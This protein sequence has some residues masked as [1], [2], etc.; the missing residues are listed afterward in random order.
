[1]RMRPPGSGRGNSFLQENTMYAH[2]ALLAGSKLLYPVRGQFK[3]GLGGGCAYG[4]ICEAGFDYACSWVFDPFGTKLPCACTGPYIMGSC[5]VP[6]LYDP[7]KYGGK[8]PM[9]AAVVHLFNWHVC[10]TK[11]WT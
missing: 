8:V 3:D 5:A 6:V 2:E 7:T 11:D 4:M 9:N 10:T 1:M